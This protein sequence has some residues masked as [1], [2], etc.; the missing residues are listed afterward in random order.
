[1]FYG[2]SSWQTHGESSVSLLMMNIEQRQ[3]AAGPQ[4]SWPRVHLQPAIVYIHRRHAF[5]ITVTQSKT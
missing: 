3:A 1:M 5:I 4:P 2:A